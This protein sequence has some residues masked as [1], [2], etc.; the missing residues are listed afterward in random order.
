MVLIGDIKY[1]FREFRLGEEKYL[2]LR[3]DGGSRMK[4]ID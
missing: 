2:G 3:I 4:D 1:F